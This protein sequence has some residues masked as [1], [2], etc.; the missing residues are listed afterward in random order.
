MTGIVKAAEM[1][2]TKVRSVYIRVAGGDDFLVVRGTRVGKQL[3]GEVGATV[4]ATGYIRE[5][6]TKDLDFS[7][8]IDVLEY[9]VVPEAVEPAANADG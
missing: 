1:Y 8:A 7:H 3:V 9:E 2:G 4:K 5:S 6:R